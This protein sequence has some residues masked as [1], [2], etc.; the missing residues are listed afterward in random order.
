VPLGLN[1][2]VIGLLNRRGQPMLVSGPIDLIGLLFGLSGFVVVGGPAILTSLHENW[3]MWWLLGDWGADRDSLDAAETWGLLVCVGYFVFVVGGC[4]W[5]FRQY[6]ALTS[7]YSVRPDVVPGVIMSV[8]RDTGIL[9]T[10]SGNRFTFWVAGDK[11]ATLDLE[12]FDALSNVT[13]R[14]SPLDTPV[15]PVIEEGLARELE[16][17]QPPDH[18][19]GLWLCCIGLFVMGLAVL[20]LFA[21]VL[22]TARR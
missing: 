4:A 17:S 2:V 14:W 20:I 5:L 21:L 9:P 15:R 7:I 8:C 16:E 3:R 12:P 18:D 1:L 11:G 10:L 6:R 22:Y 13:L 19:V